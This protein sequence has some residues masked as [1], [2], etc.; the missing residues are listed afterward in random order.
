MESGYAILERIARAGK[1]ETG[2]RKKLL[3]IAKRIYNAHKEHE[4]SK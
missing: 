2:D 3:K 4:R 1:L